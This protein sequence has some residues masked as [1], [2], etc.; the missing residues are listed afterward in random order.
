MKAFA[1]YLALLSHIGIPFCSLFPPFPRHFYCQLNSLMLPKFGDGNEL[2]QKWAILTLCSY[3][4]WKL[5]SRPY[6][7]Q[8]HSGCHQRQHSLERRMRKEYKLEMPTHKA[9]TDLK[10]RLFLQA[11]QIVSPIF[12]EWFRP[13]RCRPFLCFWEKNGWMNTTIANNW[14][15]TEDK[16]WLVGQWLCHRAIPDTVTSFWGI[17]FLCTQKFPDF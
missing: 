13:T 4:N 11:I 17:K 15:V 6:R 14:F 12:Q 16:R 10:L 8:S 7:P 5:I 9:P 3:H 1:C 2:P